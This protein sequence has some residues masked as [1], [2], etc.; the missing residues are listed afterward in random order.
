[1]GSTGRAVFR[2]LSSSGDI[3]LKSWFAQQLQQ[4]TGLQGIMISFQARSLRERVLIILAL[5]LFVIV[6]LFY[7]LIEP[8]RSQYQQ[9]AAR[10]SD[11]KKLYQRIQMNTDLLTQTQSGLVF[12]DRGSNSLRGVLTQTANQ[13]GLVADRIQVEGEG[14]IQVWSSQISFA[15]VSQWLEALA[16]QRV[17]IVALQIE[18]VESGLVNLR[19]TLD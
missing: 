3:E 7:T 5:L 17:N 10:L 12:E 2:R 4:S 13:V 8:S 16:K 19:V 9:A 14:K 1:M 15:V 6:M 18:K 11:S